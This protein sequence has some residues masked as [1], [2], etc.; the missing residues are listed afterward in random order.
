LS[1]KVLKLVHFGRSSIVWPK[2]EMSANNSSSFPERLKEFK[3]VISWQETDQ[4]LGPFFNGNRFGDPLL[5]FIAFAQGSGSLA[6]SS[7]HASF[8]LP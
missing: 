5:L 4:I 3:Q 1:K 7:R 2:D 8:A 6:A